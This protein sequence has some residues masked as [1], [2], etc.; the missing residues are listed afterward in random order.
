MVIQ[1]SPQKIYQNVKLLQPVKVIYI[2]K[3]SSNFLQRLI[4]S[5]ILLVMK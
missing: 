3:K 5:K 1:V 2:K 4:I